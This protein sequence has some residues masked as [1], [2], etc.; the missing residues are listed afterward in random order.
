MRGGKMLLLLLGVVVFMATAYAIIKQYNTTLTLLFSGILLWTLSFLF[1]APAHPLTGFQS[2]GSKI[3]DIF[4]TFTY[5]MHSSVASVGLII[6]AAGGFAKYMNTVGASDIFVLYASKPLQIIHNPYM[7]VSITVIFTQIMGLFVPSASGLSMLLLVTLFPLLR[8]FGV[9]PASAAAALASSACWEF[10]PASGSTSISAQLSDMSTM[11][12]FMDVQAP[13]AAVSTLVAAILY[14]FTSIYFDKQEAKHHSIMPTEKTTSTQKEGKNLP[15]FYALL[16]VIPLFLLLIFSEYIISSVQVDVV[17]AMF[18]SLIITVCLECI[19]TRNI[20]TVFTQALSFFA[21]MG[22]MLKDVVM[23]LV[24]AQ[25]FAKGLEAVGITDFLISTST[26]LGLGGL[27]MTL[28]LVGIIG[29]LAFVSG[30]GNAAFLAFSNLA[31]SVAKAMNVPAQAILLPMQTASGAFRSMS[32]VA[33][34]VIAISGGTG[35]SPL[36]VVKRTAIPLTGGVIANIIMA[37]ML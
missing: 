11:A 28:V 20:H 4:T 36:T 15:A 27:A 3:I 7:L 1:D 8:G 31:P 6:M 24:A 32:P 23:L 2:S 35:V 33:G 9:T 25:F 18:I 17:S 12:F 37:Q 29:L 21:G 19:R 13:A 14:Y 30:S 22:D 34:L 5:L 10:G 16:P 26:S